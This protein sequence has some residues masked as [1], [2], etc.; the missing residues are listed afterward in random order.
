M[1]TTYHNRANFAIAHHFIEL[2]RDIHA[3]KGILEK[4]ACLSS[5]N[6]L[7][8]LRIAYPNIVIAILASAIRID[9]G[10]RGEVGFVEVFFF[11]RKAYP[12]EGP[13]SIVE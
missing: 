13:I 9:A 4:N 10:H 1:V 3:A 11:A 6:K 5:Y 7:V 12:A 2:Q 8:F